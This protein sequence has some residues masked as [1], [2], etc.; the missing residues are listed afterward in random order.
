ML[1][2]GVLTLCGVRAARGLRSMRLWHLRKDRQDNDVQRRTKRGWQTSVHAVRADGIVVAMYCLQCGQNVDRVSTSREE[3]WP[4]DTSVQRMPCRMWE[5]RRGCCRY[6]SLC[7]QIANY[8]GR[9]KELPRHISVTLA[10]HHCR[11]PALTRKSSI[12][13]RYTQESAYA[14][15]AKLSATARR[16]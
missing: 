4:Y 12:L 14:S 10:K 6:A 11:V 13:R 15:I 16:M 5:M 9:V 2:G 8:A 3:G 7:H 1:R